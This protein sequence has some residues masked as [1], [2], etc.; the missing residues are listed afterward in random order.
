M[1]LVLFNYP[2]TNFGNYQISSLSSRS[3][4]ADCSC[5]VLVNP[6]AFHHEDDPPYRCDVVARVAVEGD[7]VGLH[8]GREWADFVLHSE[9]LCGAGVR[10]DQGVHQA[11]AGLRALDE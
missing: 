10:G 5:L 1:S 3:F 4:A 7:D 2:I 6:S 11:L 9:G 8:S